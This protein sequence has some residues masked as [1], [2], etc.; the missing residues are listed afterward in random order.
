MSKRYHI[1]K[2]GRPA[3]CHAKEKCP[4]GLPSEHFSTLEEALAYSDSINESVIGFEND[5]KEYY[6]SEQ[7]EKDLL[8]LANSSS[9]IARMKAI[10]YGYR[11]DTLVDDPNP[12]VRLHLAEKGLYTIE[13]QNDPDK[14][15]REK[16]KEKDIEVSK[17]DK[18]LIADIDSIKKSRNPELEINSDS[19]E[20]DKYRTAYAREKWRDKN[21]TNIKM[22]FNSAFELSKVEG[23]MSYDLSTGE[24]QRTGM[25]VSKFVEHSEGV[26]PKDYTPER[27]QQYIDKHKDVFEN[28]PRAVVGV[29][30][31]TEADLYILDISQRTYNASY[32]RKISE[33]YDQVA[34]FDTTNFDEVTVDRNATSGGAY[35]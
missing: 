2:S 22:D 35:N 19:K 9:Y 17:A 32:A 7:T 10:D 30:H 5:F 14:N 29:W 4:L 12:R 11:S 34:F 24:I 27:L 31:D 15:I 23:G 13:L 6:N 20:Y 26:K 8:K 3:V 21:S 18:A 33:D 28:T 25:F 16:A 1:G